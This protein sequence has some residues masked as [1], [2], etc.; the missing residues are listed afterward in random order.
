MDSPNAVGQG[1][2]F[3]D[4]SGAT[5]GRYR[6]ESLL[7]SGGMGEVY[8]AF[9]TTLK[10]RVAIKRMAATKC[11][12]KASRRRFMREAQN[13]S[14]LNDQRIAGVHDVLEKDDEIFLVM[15]YVE[16]STLRRRLGSP[17][18]ME[19]FFKIAL[20][21]AKGVQA[22]HERGII[23]HDI[24][25]E[26]IMITP[27]GTVKILDFGVACRLPSNETNVTTDASTEELSSTSGGTLAYMA[28]EVLL[29]EKSGARA[30][31]FSMGLVFFEM[32]S[33]Q[34]PYRGATVT[35]TVDNILHGRAP[36]LET[37][38]PSV[39]RQITELIKRM[40][41]RD[42]GGRPQNAA[43]VG[44]SLCMIQSGERETFTVR[45][46]R[47][48]R[49]WWL[50]RLSVAAAI[51]VL[52]LISP[53]AWRALRDR[54][55][56]GVM[57]AERILVV[58]PLTNLSAGGAGQNLC[59]GLA[60]V[61][62]SSL[63]RMSTQ[64]RVIDGNVVYARKIGSIDEAIKEFRVTLA[65]TGSFL[66]LE[67]RLR[68]DLNL[69]NARDSTII[70]TLREE[71]TLPN[72][73]WLQDAVLPQLAQM[74]RLPR[75]AHLTAA[76]GTVASKALELYLSG[77]G[78]LQNYDVPGNIDRAI[79]SFW[80]ATREDAS[81]A[82]AFAAL[83]EAYWEK[84]GQTN[85]TKW[86]GQARENCDKALLFDGRLPAAHIT[87]GRIH[88]GTG[89]AEQAT[90]DFRRALDLDPSNADAYLHLASAL[91]KIGNLDGAEQNYLEAIRILPGAWRGYNELA[92]FY[93]FQGRRQDAEQE[94]L[95]AL[96]LRPDSTYLLSNLG[97]AYFAQERWDEARR[98]FQKRL[99]LGPDATAYSNLGTLEFKLGRYAE[100]ASMFERAIQ[101]ERGDYR[102]WGNLASAQ[103]RIPGMEPRARMSAEQA[104]RLVDEHLKV[105]PSD[106]N[107]LAAAA[108]FNSLLGKRSV[109]VNY[110]KRALKLQP[111]NVEIIYSAA[112]I[113]EQ[114]GDRRE[115][116]EWIGK[117]LEKG[118]SR[119]WIE[120]SP[121]LVDLRKDPGYRRLVAEKA[122]K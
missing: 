29:G 47:L 85:E 80:Q 39:P 111:E 107:A 37:L 95:K 63:R 28:P 122:G 108:D 58:L 24:K 12:D 41:A 75:T 46:L 30:D 5:V 4:L 109:A 118:Y 34:H 13:A 61:L 25:P 23:H 2:R 72:L 38:N 52:M 67:D 21:C 3:P 27:E 84:Y 49:K 19:D 86:I 50:R 83:G 53:M 33:A 45:L 8:R 89:Q 100:A 1:G 54:A 97:A 102:V 92:A 66:L 76:Q 15:E 65:L 79:Q 14:A 78:L 115:A 106:A 6:I 103:R 90:R 22:A 40:M 117:A 64:C 32:L 69:V 44:A 17:M 119:A 35:A 96:E 18:S 112:H 120:S 93:Y 105:D 87:L 101:I 91:E 114:L 104:A 26:N 48:F 82:G 42:P 51:L 16:G 57:P 98:M 20:E 31:V 71:M 94:W 113:Y 70:D 36:A 81:Y 55:T 74:L 43:E 11:M 116:L 77:R 56:T 99:D 110:L 73:I 7:G 60:I 9:D 121:D 10:R 62:P 68:L 59:D 88:S